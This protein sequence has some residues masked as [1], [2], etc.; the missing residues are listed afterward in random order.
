MAHFHFPN[1][2]FHTFYKFNSYL[3]P[4]KRGNMGKPQSKVELLSQSRDNYLKLQSFINAL[5][6]EEQER[7][8]PEG[9]LNRNIR[10]VLA[11]LHAWHLMMN[12]W[13][14]VGM[15][16]EKPEIPAKGYTWKTTPDLNTEIQK[17]Y[18]D[19]L[20]DEIKQKLEL[21]HQTMLALIETH[22]DEE[23]FEKKRY[24]WTGS[25]SLGAYFISATSSH[26]DWALKLIK[27]CRK[28]I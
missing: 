21:S 23:L 28:G 14:T 7:A 25:T 22:S 15:T 8:F 17:R 4:K 18:T 9:T 2:A 12:D 26:Y 3:L 16:G 27:R 11:H 20:L 5:S 6:T 24:K 10:D 13:Y 1:V 19:T